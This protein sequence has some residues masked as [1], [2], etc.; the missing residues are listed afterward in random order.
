MFKFDKYQE[1]KQ[2]SHKLCSNFFYAFNKGKIH[3][4]KMSWTDGWT[5]LL[6]FG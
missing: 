4:A 2:H 3:V 6:S 1:K 5:I